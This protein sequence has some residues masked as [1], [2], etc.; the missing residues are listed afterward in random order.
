LGEHGR[1]RCYTGRVAPICGRQ[2]SRGGAMGKARGAVRRG[3]CRHPAT[4]AGGRGKGNSFPWLT[5]GPQVAVRVRR[6]RGLV[7]WAVKQAE[8]GHAVQGEA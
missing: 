4:S 5:H 1:L 3:P 7:G 2:R 8:L 6:G